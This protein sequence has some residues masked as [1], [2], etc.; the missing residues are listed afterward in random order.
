M[1]L[2]K[3]FVTSIE[4]YKSFKICRKTNHGLI[5]FHAGIDSIRPRSPHCCN[6][7]KN[8]LMISR[9]IGV[10]LRERSFDQVTAYAPTFANGGTMTSE[11]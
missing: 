11:I 10:V 4:D 3:F 1:P 2:I 9:D 5:S 7:P 8:E 6:S